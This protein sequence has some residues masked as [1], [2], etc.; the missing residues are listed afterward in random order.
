MKQYT[1]LYNKSDVLLLANVMENF[2]TVCLNTYKLDPARFY[3]APGLAWSAMLK[4][5]KKEFDMLTD[6]DMI[7]MLT[8]VMRGGLS[9]CSTRCAVANNPNMK[10]NFN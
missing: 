3:T 1:L 8:K 7:L 4:T 2:R 5:T 10:E 9:K 6:Y